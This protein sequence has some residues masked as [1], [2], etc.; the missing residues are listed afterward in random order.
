MEVPLVHQEQGRQEGL[1]P[2]ASGRG[3]ASRPGPPASGTRTGTGEGRFLWFKPPVRG[4]W[5]QDGKPIQLLR[6]VP[7]PAEVALAG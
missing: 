5:S 6:Q 2:A 7:D 3:S 4:P 1:L